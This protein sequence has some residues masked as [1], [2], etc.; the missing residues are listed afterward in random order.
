LS[1]HKFTSIEPAGAL[2]SQARGINARGEI[3]GTFTGADNVPHAFLFNK[4]TFTLT[5]VPGAL[6][7]R[8]RGI[9]ARGQIS[10]NY[11]DSTGNTHG[12]EAAR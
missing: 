10:G 3:V 11:V 12:F 4:G 6:V 2:T 1:D 9:N 5:D 7:T 8:S